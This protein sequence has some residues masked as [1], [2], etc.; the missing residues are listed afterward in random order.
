MYDGC[1]DGGVSFK[2][3]MVEK[4]EESYHVMQSHGG[5]ETVCRHS[6]FYQ[7]LY[8]RTYIFYMNDISINLSSS[9]KSHLDADPLM[10]FWYI[11]FFF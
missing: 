3:V 8:I 4:T 6:N 2:A 5:G 7:S 10:T 1:Q 11:F 9:Q